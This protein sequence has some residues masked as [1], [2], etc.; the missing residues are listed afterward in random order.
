MWM[1]GAPAG[2]RLG[3]QREGMSSLRVRHSEKGQV[4]CI[5]VPRRWCPELAGDPFGGGSHPSP[6]RRGSC[7]A[8]GHPEVG[9]ESWENQNGTQIFV[10]GR[11]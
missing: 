4:G 8:D 6:L 1:E 3:G 9:S 5:S 2:S 7:L 11:S 10:S